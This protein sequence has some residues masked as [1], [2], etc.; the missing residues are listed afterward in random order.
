MRATLQ[1]NGTA[2]DTSVPWLVGCDGGHS[3]VREQLGL[4][5]KGE[6]T[7]TWL[8]ADA[9]ITSARPVGDRRWRLLDTVDVDYTGDDTAVAER[10]THKL[11]RGPGIPSHVEHPTWVSVF[12]IQQRAAPMMQSGRCFLA[13]DA[14]HVHSPSL[15]TPTAPSGYRSRTPC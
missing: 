5:L 12:T 10:F 8:V 3:T 9:D 13:G 15:W 1:R 4:V 6:S 11:S 14:A 2:E 7:E